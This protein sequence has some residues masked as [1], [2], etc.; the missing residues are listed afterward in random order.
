MIER[1]DGKKTTVVPLPWLP[2][3]MGQRATLIPSTNRETTERTF[4]GG[5]DGNLT[6]FLD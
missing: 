2:M 6:R 3:P 4:L 5:K 1:I